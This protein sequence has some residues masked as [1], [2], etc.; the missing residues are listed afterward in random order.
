MRGTSVVAF[1]LFLLFAGFNSA[2][3][4]SGDIG[5]TTVVK[6]KITA[7]P[8][9][10][11]PGYYGITVK[12][13]LAAFTPGQL[14]FDPETQDSAVRFETGMVSWSIL[15]FAG[16]GWRGHNGKYRT[17]RGEFMAKLDVARGQVDVTF[18]G[19]VDQEVVNPILFRVEF[20][21]ALGQ[22]QDTWTEN[23][24]KPSSF[25]YP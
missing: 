5:A 17:G 23:P 9:R 22:T 20:G 6:G 4:Y 1:A 2:A 25:A 19:N 7:K 21:P 10:R 3:P 13:R 16:L 12:A 18:K 15:G 8:D 24:K 11:N 14:S